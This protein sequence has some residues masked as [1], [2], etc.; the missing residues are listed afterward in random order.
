MNGVF[1]ATMSDLASQM[2]LSAPAAGAD[3]AAE[4]GLRALLMTLCRNMEDVAPRNVSVKA[5]H[6]G[7]SLG[8]DDLRRLHFDDGCRIPGG[9]RSSSLHWEHWLPVAEMRRELM[10]LSDP[11]PAACRAVLSKAR[12]CWILKEE[13]DRLSELGFRSRRPDPDAAYRAAGIELA[14]PWDGVKSAG[15]EY[16]R[17]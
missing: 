13:D 4:R 17:S 10:S 6:R 16:L 3:P 7:R 12:L 15:G 5:A 9:R 2:V 11:T 1:L 8:I 14:Y